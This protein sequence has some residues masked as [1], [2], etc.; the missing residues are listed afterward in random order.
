[1]KF[2]E[3]AEPFYQI[4]LQYCNWCENFGSNVAQ[5]AFEPFISLV[6]S[7]FYNAVLLQPSEA[8]DPIIEREAR[9]KA[10]LLSDQ[11]NFSSLPFGFYRDLFD[12]SPESEE[13]PTLGD[14]QDDLKD[15]Y[16]EL[17]TGIFMWEMGFCS[18]A[19]NQ[20]AFSFRVHWGRHAVCALKAMF[21]RL[22][23]SRFL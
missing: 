18:Q 10:T 16:T 6:A 4:A 7:T 12:D 11:L 1:M 19:E 3:L 20:W 5:L 2:N 8:A 23:T 17:K 13:L 14:I 22:T 9:L 15:I 21:P